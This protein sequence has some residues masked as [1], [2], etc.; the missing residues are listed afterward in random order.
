MRST[1][2]EKD[3]QIASVA[4]L[5]GARRRRGARRRSRDLREV[6]RARGNVFA[7]LMDAVKVA[8]L[9]QISGALYEVG[10]RVPA[11]HVDGRGYVRWPPSRASSPS[12]PASPSCSATSG[13]PSE[14]VG[15]TGFCIHPWETVRT[16]P[17][18]GGTKDVKMD[19][20]RELAPTHV[21][22]NVDEN[23]QARTPRRSPSSSPT[24]S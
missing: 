2:A 6:A 17:K 22:V 9:G 24:S 15:R 16:I 8:S 12:S 5:P 4:G 11:Q 20:V 1:D 21:V 23:R 19:R 7:A 14:L 18:V 3:D 10:R 13:W